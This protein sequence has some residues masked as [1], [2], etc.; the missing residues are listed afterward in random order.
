MMSE[1]IKGKSFWQSVNLVLPFENSSSIEFNM[2]DE[3]LLILLI[4]FLPFPCLLK[5]FSG[6]LSAF[7]SFMV[8]SRDEHFLS[9]I[10]KFLELF[11]SFSTKWILSSDFWVLVPLWLSSSRSKDQHFLQITFDLSLQGLIFDVS[12]FICSF[13]FVSVRNESKM[14]YL[15]EMNSLW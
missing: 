3:L 10:L 2:L 1:Y 4:K 9:I 8:S 6:S 5:L 7:V 15:F 14:Q 11:L 12:E 13:L